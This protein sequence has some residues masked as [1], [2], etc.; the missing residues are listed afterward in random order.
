MESRRTAVG[1]EGMRRQ[2]EGLGKKEKGREKL[3]DWWGRWKR[4]WGDTW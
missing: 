2:V 3:T 1:S 4:G